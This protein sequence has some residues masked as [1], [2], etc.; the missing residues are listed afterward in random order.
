MIRIAICDDDKTITDQIEVLM[1]KN[2]IE[3]KIVSKA[4]DVFN[5]SQNL[6]TYINN[7]NEYD[8]IYLDIEMP[9]MDGITLARKIRENNREVV[10][11]YISS[12]DNYFVDLFP[13]LPF[14]FLRKPIDKEQFAI[15]FKAAFQEIN[16]T[17]YYFYYDYRSIRYRVP[18]REIIYFESYGRNVYIVT[19][20]K[21]ERFLGKLNDL[22]KRLAEQKAQ[23]LRIHQSYLINAALMEVLNFD[24]V[25]MCNGETL[26]ISQDRKKHI[27][28]QYFRM[29]K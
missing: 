4:L 18:I 5:S 29:E 19:K 26:R 2:L 23:F 17:D 7:N 11:I 3:N 15:D 10:F 9:E 20:T 21:K 6:L 24:Y 13:V 22:E 12:H 25:I 8:L 16:R 14:R 27:R 28:E 1:E